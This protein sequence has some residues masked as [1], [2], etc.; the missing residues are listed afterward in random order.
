[1]TG[2]PPTPWTRV[3]RLVVVATGSASAAFLPYWANLL[4]VTHP[5]LAFRVVVTHSAERFVTLASV[6]AAGADRVLRDAWPEPDAASAPHVELSTWAQGFLVYPASFNFVARLALGLGDTPALLA[7][8]CTAAPVVLAPSLPPG[9]P[10]SPAYRQHVATLGQRPR[11]VVADPLPGRSITTGRDDAWLPAP[12][13]GVLALLDE[14]LAG[15]AG[16]AWT[17]DAQPAAGTVGA[18]G[19]AAHGTRG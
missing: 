9:G 8:Q 16:G 11:T 12:L 6:A 13:P 15:D 17:D 18:P 5:G 14:H 10:R 1:M 19:P 2:L 4:H 3:E 7:A